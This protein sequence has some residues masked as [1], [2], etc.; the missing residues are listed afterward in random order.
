MSHTF[1]RRGPARLIRLV[2]VPLMA[3]LVTALVL[4]SG[5]T[6]GS[7]ETAR[8]AAK[9]T[10]PLLAAAPAPVHGVADNGAV[11]DGTFELKRFDA[12]DGVLYAV[13]KLKGSLGD[14]NVRQ[15]VRLPVTGAESVPNPATGISG[16][17]GT[18]GLKQQPVPTPGACDLLTLAL[19]PLDLDLLGLRVAL[20]EVNLLLE[21]IPGA[22][23]LV[24]NLLCSVAGLLDPGP[25]GLPGLI[26]GLLDAIANLLNGLLGGL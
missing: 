5:A 12:R 14:G 24:G 25:V 8:S 21:A 6:A 22:G 4:A 10:D 26:Q 2:A 1:T 9:P 20:D 15:N 17:T 16:I 19:G 13:G 3:G 7:T 11:F 23:N 18:N